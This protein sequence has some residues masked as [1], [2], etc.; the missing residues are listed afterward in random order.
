[1]MQNSLLHLFFSLNQLNHMNDSTFRQKISNFLFVFKSFYLVKEFD[2]HS[3]YTE[4]D[5]FQ[6]IKGS[7][8]LEQ[9]RTSV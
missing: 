1:M 7:I 8:K 2:H 3:K 5:V 9:T 4:P 6:M